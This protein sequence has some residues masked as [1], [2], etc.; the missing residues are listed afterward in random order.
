MS[1]QPSSDELGSVGR[2]CQH[3]RHAGRFEVPTAHGQ[4]CLQG[5]VCLLQ[6]VQAAVPV[7]E[8]FLETI[9]NGGHNAGF[10]AIDVI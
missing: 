7:R 9:C 10:I 6:L 3:R 2:R 8:A 4:G 1:H 5:G